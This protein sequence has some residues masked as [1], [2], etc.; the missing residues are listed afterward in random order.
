MSNQRIE[1]R[2]RCMH[3]SC[4]V[5]CREG[6]LRMSEELFNE[7]SAAYE[8]PELFRSPKGACRIGFN[9]PYRIIK[10]QKLSEDASGAFN[11]KRGAFSEDPIFLLME[12]HQE[13]IKRLDNLETAIRTRD[14][15]TLWQATCVLENHI[16]LHSACKEENV[17]FPIIKDHL[18]L[19]EGLIQIM[20]EDHSE[21]LSLLHSFRN[22][23]EDGTILDG[24]IISMTVSL[25][26]HIRKEDNEF[27][28]LI[29]EH[30]NEELSVK[31][32]E[33]FRKIE[34][35]FVPLEPG[36]REKLQELK[37]EERAKRAHMDEEIM[38]LK[39]NSMDSCCGH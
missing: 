18:P 1:I 10:F 20:N 30:L 7:L 33:G 13:I 34:A 32:V 19:G 9:Q 12:D 28:K 36:D 37:K 5:N 27:F 24:I 11:E 3:P 23:L 39:Q 31:L 4:C 22:A 2:Y 35:E 17:L 14:I 6:Y 16:N 25:K 8:D 26:S 15:D 21:I 29:E 38:A